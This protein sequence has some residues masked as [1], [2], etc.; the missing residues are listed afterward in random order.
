MSEINTEE[1]LTVVPEK[2]MEERLKDLGIKAYLNEKDQ[3]VLIQNGS[4]TLCHGCK[5]Y[6]DNELYLESK[7]THSPVTFSDSLALMSGL[8]EEVRVIA[9]DLKLRPGGVGIASTYT[10]M[11]R[12]GGY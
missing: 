2:S 10:Y 3:L 8:Q 7:L 11:T 5:I 9:R 1:A 6:V 12:P 4:L